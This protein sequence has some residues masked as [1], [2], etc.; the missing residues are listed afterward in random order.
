MGEE[1]RE[2]GRGRGHLF[3]FMRA[4]NSCSAQSWWVTSGVWLS[5]WCTS[6]SFA[7][8][9]EFTGGKNGKSIVGGS[10]GAPCKE[11]LSAVRWRWR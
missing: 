5:F 7:P 10:I 3:L 11:N 1:R 8:S 9:G 6:I 2:R 4:W